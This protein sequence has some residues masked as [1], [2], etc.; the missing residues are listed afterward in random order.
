MIYRDILKKDLGEEESRILGQTFTAYCYDAVVKAPFV[1]GAYEF[2]RD[3]HQALD[4]FVVSGTPEEEMISIVKEKQ[5]SHFFKG[6]YGSPRS[7]AELISLILREHDLMAEEIVFVGDAA[8]DQEGAEQAGV[9]F[10]GRIHENYAN[11]FLA[12]PEG[13]LIRDI[14]DLKKLISSE[15]SMKRNQKEVPHVS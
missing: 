7:K 6:V 2:L 15:K 11:P 9:R 13:R 12:I 8:S 1:R 4:L 14:I 5:L 3:Y 10:I